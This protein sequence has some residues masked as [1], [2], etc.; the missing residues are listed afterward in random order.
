MVTKEDVEAYYSRLPMLRPPQEII[1]LTNREIGADT[2]YD[3]HQWTILG[4][5]KQG[6]HSI[7]VAGNA[8]L[9][10]YVHESLHLGGV[11]NE[12][13]TRLLTRMALMKARW[14]P[15]L[16]KQ[17]HYEAVPVSAQEKRAILDRLHLSGPAVTEA[18]I[19]R[20]VYQPVAMDMHLSDPRSRL[21]QLLYRP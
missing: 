6:E 18:E 9:S 3:A 11:R 10:T 17:V 8:P 12:A 7:T 1:V 15:G 19:I 13:A 16:L 14:S 5:Q 20:L 4:M 21:Q 2:L